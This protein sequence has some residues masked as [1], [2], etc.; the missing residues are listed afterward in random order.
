MI[1]PAENENILQ[2][3]SS[4][5]AVIFYYIKDPGFNKKLHRK[6]KVWAIPK[7]NSSRKT[8]SLRKHRYCTYQTKILS[9]IFLKKSHK[10]RK[11]YL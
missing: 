8:L 5:T 6:R 10:W 4:T 11:Q 9:Y 2:I 3:K 1:C 7:K